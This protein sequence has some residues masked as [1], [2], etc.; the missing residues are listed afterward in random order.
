[1]MYMRRM[2]QM[3]CLSMSYLNFL[4]LTKEYWNA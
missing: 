1:M 4:R 2:M 3:A